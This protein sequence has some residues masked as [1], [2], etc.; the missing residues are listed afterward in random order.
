MEEETDFNQE[1]CIRNMSKLSEEEEQRYKEQAITSMQVEIVGQN[2]QKE[3]QYRLSQKSDKSL[4][5]E[6]I[7]DVNIQSEYKEDKQMIENDTE[8]VA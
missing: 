3:E 1:A 8:K 4:E 5:D 7:S 6:N 2:F